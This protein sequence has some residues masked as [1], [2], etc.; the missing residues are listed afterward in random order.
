MN[1]SAACI[2]FT[3]NYRQYR[4]SRSI[5]RG[6]LGRTGGPKRSSGIPSWQVP[7]KRRTNTRRERL[8]PRQSCSGASGFGRLFAVQHFR[9]D[10]KERESV[11]VWEGDENPGQLQPACSLPHGLYPRISSSSSLHLIWILSPSIPLSL[12]PPFRPKHLLSRFAVA[13]AVWTRLVVRF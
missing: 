5:V 10:C 13:G 12:V 4:V 2:A 1:Y 3:Q 8:R 11:W 7:E 6:S 9:C